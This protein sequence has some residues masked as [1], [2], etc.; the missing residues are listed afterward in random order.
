MTAR[1][2]KSISNSAQLS[3][4]LKQHLLA[5]HY[6]PGD[7]IET[8]TELARRFQVSRSKIREVT[9]MLQR[10]GLLSRKQ[11]AGSTICALDPSTIGEDLAF[12]FLLAGLE[13]AG[14]WEARRVIELSILPLVV[15]RVTPAHLQKMDRAID[16]MEASLGNPDAAD[17][18]DR[19]FHLVVLQACGNEILQSLGAVIHE[20]FRATIRRKYWKAELFRKAIKEHRALVEAIRAEDLSRAQQILEAHLLGK[21]FRVGLQSTRKGRLL[22]SSDSDWIS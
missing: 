1:L 11:R 10:Q 21:P 5:K 15:R 4:R 6:S 7:R 18:A 13:D 22:K 16:R 14:A 3:S 19:D 8:E 9:T 17:R 2:A 20:L 12:R